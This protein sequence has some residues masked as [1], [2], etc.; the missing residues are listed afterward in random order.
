MKE[1]DQN[2][3]NEYQNLKFNLVK[4]GKITEKKETYLFLLDMHF[5]VSRSLKKL[6][7]LMSTQTVMCL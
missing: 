7:R 3:I 1:V 5:T 6:F 4:E 2:N